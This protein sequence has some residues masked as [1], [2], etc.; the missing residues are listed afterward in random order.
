MKWFVI[1][2]MLFDAVIKFIKPQP[3]I[4]TTISELGYKEHHILFHGLSALLCTLFFMFPRTAILG[5]VL[6]TA[7][8][9]GAVA[10]HLR[11]D[12]PLS[13]IHCFPYTL[14]FYYG[15]VC[16]CVVSEFVA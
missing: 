15:Q 11:V 2:F 9:G 13:A 3:V 5:A 10:S 4:E 6:M 8:L 12:N 16:G 14:V 1:I 7:H